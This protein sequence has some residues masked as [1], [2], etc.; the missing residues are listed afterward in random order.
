M[1]EATLRKLEKMPRPEELPVA[2]ARV[3]AAK[4]TLADQEDMF[5]RAKQLV[6]DAALPREELTRRR[7]AVDVA[8]AQVEQA[9]AELKLLK[10]GAWEMEKAIAKARLDLAQAQVQQIHDELE[11][12]VVRAPIAGE[13]LQINVRAGEFAATPA[14]QPLIVLGNV[15]KLHLRVDID[16]EDIPRFR[17]SAKAV[18]FLR[19]RPQRRYNLTLIRVEPSVIPKRSLSGGSGPDRVD[20]RVQQ[21]LYAIELEG[22]QPLY[23]GQQLDVFIEAE[24]LFANGGKK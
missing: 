20:T 7:F 10:S 12:L 21:V 14:P 18:G 24:P 15:Q 4:A 16:E 6:A 11:R 9:E 5:K 13:V 8:R 17:P 23:I 3:N 19:S 2:E 22:S 1:A